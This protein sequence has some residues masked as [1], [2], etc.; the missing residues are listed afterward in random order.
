MTLAKT[1]KRFNSHELR[2]RSLNLFPGGRP[3]GL[4]LLGGKA[5]PAVAR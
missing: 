3:L 2:L 4:S 1:Q 5:G